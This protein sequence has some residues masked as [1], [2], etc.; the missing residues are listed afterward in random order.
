MGSK[1]EVNTN[2][3]VVKGIMASPTGY[4][5]GLKIKP[6]ATN[7]TYQIDIEPGQCRND[8]D[9]GD[10]ILSSTLTI[11]ITVSGKNGLDTGTETDS[12]WYY[13]W[14]IRNPSTGE[15]A[16][17][18][19]TSSTSPTLPSGFTEKR[20]IG[21]VRNHSDGNFL[22]FAQI[23]NGSTR[24]YLYHEFYNRTAVL[25]GGTGSYPSVVDCSAYIPP[26]TNIGIFAI[27]QG[28]VDDGSTNPAVLLSPGDMTGF[29]EFW[30]IMAY[31]GMIEMDTDDS[32]CIQYGTS[33]SPQAKVS[34]YVKG[35]I[36]EV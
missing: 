32:Q 7:P 2:G 5:R 4:I 30:T 35:F 34:I 9:T 14:I 27:W 26:T 1:W 12:T 36:E 15:V 8:A 10:I 33:A 16:G 3:E 29:I 6:N 20:R 17:L 24:K 22:K 11:D 21:V 19:S 13:V 18:F 25:A 23:G 28:T 31:D